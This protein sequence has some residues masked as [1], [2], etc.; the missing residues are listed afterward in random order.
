MRVRSRGR[1]CVRIC[2]IHVCELMFSKRLNFMKRRGS[3]TL[4]SSPY[5]LC[6]I[7]VLKRQHD[8][9]S[10]RG[11]RCY[12]SHA[13][14]LHTMRYAGVL[15][16]RA[17]CRIVCTY[18]RGFSNANAIVFHMS[19]RADYARSSTCEA[20]SLLYRE[21]QPCSPALQTALQLALTS[22]ASFL[23]VG[24]RETEDKVTQ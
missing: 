3:Q 19:F 22:W 6:S 1:G 20:C 5:C 9:S 12:N 24:L 18:A 16:W 14:P 8:V 7:S 2:R 10:V 4:F 17:V 15:T 23:R 11:L 21:L 13:N